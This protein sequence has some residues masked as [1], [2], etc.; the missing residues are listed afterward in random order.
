VMNSGK[1]SG[2]LIFMCVL[3]LC[4][5]MRL[6]GD[7]DTTFL[8]FNVVTGLTKGII[9]LNIYRRSRNIY[10]D[11]F[12]LMLKKWTRRGITVHRA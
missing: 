7:A 1:A 8:Q 4:R 6:T 2:G 9:C 5:C 11:K 10:N 3:R 12:R